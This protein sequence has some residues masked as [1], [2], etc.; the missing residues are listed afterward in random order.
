[1]SQRKN[2]NWVYKGKR[3]RRSGLE[4]Q[5]DRPGHHADNRVIG[6]SFM[7]RQ[8]VHGYEY[9]QSITVIYET[10]GLLG[11]SVT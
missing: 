9:G 1:M 2:N 7:L 3:K 4:R 10:V 6:Y 11:V 8:G 5:A